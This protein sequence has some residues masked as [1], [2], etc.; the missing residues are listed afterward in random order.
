MPSF[1]SVTII[2]TLG[3]DP[4]LKTLAGGTAVCEF[5]LAVNRQWTEKSGQKKTSVTWI[6]VV[7][8]GRQAEVICQY[9]KRGDSFLVNG[10]HEEQSW[11]DRQSG[12]KR[13]KLRVVCE[14][15]TMLGSSEKRDREPAPRNTT[16]AANEAF[17]GDFT[18]EDPDSIPF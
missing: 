15:M 7:A 1:D 5:S 17:G 4:E 8:W 3:K 10:R 18:D 2:G 16:A 9:L 14:S 6:P 11:E 12:Q 13:S